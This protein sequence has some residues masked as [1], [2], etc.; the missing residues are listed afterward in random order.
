MNVLLTHHYF[1]P[2]FAGGGEYVVLETARGLLRRGVNVRVLTTGDRRITEYEG[3]PTVRIPVHRYAFNL[4]YHKILEM[5]H[6][7]DLIQTFN[8]HAC[9]PSLRAGKKLRKPVVCFILGMCQDAWNKLRTPVLGPIWAAWERYTLTRDFSRV[10]F[11]SEHS[12]D[13]G[14][15]LGVEPRRSV[16]NCPGI[17]LD[18]YGPASEKEDVVFFT[19]RL[20][21][22]R[23]V[24]NVIATAQAL[25]HVKFRIMGWGPL[26][27]RLPS[28]VP[29][30][31]EVV[32]FERGEP[33]RRA[34]A[35]ARI[36]FLPSRAETFGIA[37]VEAMASG[38]A[39]IS[40]ANLEFEGV[41][42][43]AND[44]GPM[45]EAVSRLWKDRTATAYMGRRNVELAQQYS[46]DRYTRTMLNTYSQVLNGE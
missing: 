45:V 32:P 11:A 36:F 28:M 9:L 12:R 5:A 29:A 3:V 37:L 34:F 4:A 7:V 8:Y 26:A 15:S 39:V 23:G 41:R 38:C 17:E 40:S 13:V 10:V 6:G 42:V 19:G 31:V 35:A 30:N 16:V 44:R 2:D 27:S 25:P 22:R 46:W 20:D 1:P 18:S 14:L 24:D 21:E 33:L 43:G